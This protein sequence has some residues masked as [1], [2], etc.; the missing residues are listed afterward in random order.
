MTKCILNCEYTCAYSKSVVIFQGFGDNKA[1]SSPQP[2]EVK[3]IDGIFIHKVA[4]GFGHTL[5]LARNDTEEEK[6]KIEELP[7]YQ[8]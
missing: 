7:E 1:K 4:C 6:S 3:T 2:Q 5:L 8:P